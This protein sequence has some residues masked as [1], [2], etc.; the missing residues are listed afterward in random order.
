MAHQP[1]GSCNPPAIMLTIWARV[2]Q[3]HPRS[4]LRP[5]NSW[6]P[7]TSSYTFDN[8]LR[9]AA[10]DQVQLRRKVDFGNSAY[11]SIDTRLACPPNGWPIPRS[12]SVRQDHPV[13][14]R[15]RRHVPS[16][17]LTTMAIT[18][19]SGRRATEQF[20]LLLQLSDQPDMQ[21][22]QR[23]R[24]PRRPRLP[25]PAALLRSSGTTPGISPLSLDQRA[26]YDDV[27]GKLRGQTGTRSTVP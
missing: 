25:I 11:F 8:D 15:E 27:V 10:N 7:K 21:R 5:L 20:G 18:H 26:Q 3:G 24:L 22:I 23:Q 17:G 16:A 4:Y 2:S 1:V 12:S 14:A 9:F 13:V 19:R 6:Q